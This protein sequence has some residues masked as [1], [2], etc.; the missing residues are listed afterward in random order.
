MTDRTCEL[1]PNPIGD[2]AFACRS[3]A[4]TATTHLRAVHEWLAEALD[5]AIGKRTAL[6]TRTGGNPTKASEAPLPIAPAALEASTVL[7]HTLTEWVRLVHNEKNTRPL[8]GPL[9]RACTHPSCRTIRD[10]KLPPATTA[11][12]ARWL[13]TVPAWARTRTWGVEMI[14][15]I[16]AAVTHAIRAVDKPIRYVPLDAACR[17]TTLDGNTPHVCGGPLT[18]ILAPGLPIDGQVRCATGDRDHTTTVHAE[19]LAQRRSDRVR[20]EV[21]TRVRS[22]Y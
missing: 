3:C 8:H 19:N 17:H 6:H 9:C 7:R 21:L 1:C 5:D 14:D 18:A 4:T 12:M 15:E 2:D 11:G 13:A 16:N 10:P 22:S 20:K